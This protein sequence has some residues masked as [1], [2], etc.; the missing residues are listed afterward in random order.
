[1]CMYSIR[2]CCTV[3]TILAGLHLLNRE[4]SP[5]LICPAL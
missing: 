5:S 2:D 4:M 1:M 3:A